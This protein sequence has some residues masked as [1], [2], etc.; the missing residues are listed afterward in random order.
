MP[1]RRPRAARSYLAAKNTQRLM[2]E[3]TVYV[4]YVYKDYRKNVDVKVLA[5]FTSRDAAIGY[6]EG[7]CVD[8][9]SEEDPEDEDSEAEYVTAIDAIFDAYCPTHGRRL[10]VQKTTLAKHGNV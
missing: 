1:S 7:L 8:K 9:D 10:A 3:A 6:A 5:V 2:E 4:A